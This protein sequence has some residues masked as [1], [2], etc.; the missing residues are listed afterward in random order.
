MRVWKPV[1][2]LLNKVRMPLFR[3]RRIKELNARK[4]ELLASIVREKEG[5]NWSREQLGRAPRAIQGQEMNALGVRE[6]VQTRQALSET[7]A[8]I[9]RVGQ[10]S[11]EKLT[12]LQAQLQKVN[13]ELGMLKG[14]N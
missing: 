3:N 8:K 1:K 11:E 7:G 6:R 2:K 10:E 14:N 9:R 12:Q 13:T 5:I 4:T